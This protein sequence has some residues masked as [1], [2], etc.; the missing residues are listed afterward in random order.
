M[1]S[2]DEGAEPQT[3]AIAT[4]TTEAD[5]ATA[6]ASEHGQ[7]EGVSEVYA[8]IR[9]AAGN[10]ALT[11][12]AGHVWR[13]V[14]SDHSPVEKGTAVAIQLEPAEAFQMNRID[15]RTFDATLVAPGALVT[16]MGQLRDLGVKVTVVAGDADAS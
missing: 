1:P 13:L 14:Y 12:L 3:A 9:Q 16:A 11:E 10:G 2:A 5:D 4:E 15:A 7:V 8:A 6:I